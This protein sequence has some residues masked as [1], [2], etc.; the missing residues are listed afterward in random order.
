[1]PE[2]Y[3][4][5]MVWCQG[6]PSPKK[7]Q[8]LVCSDNCTSKVCTTEARGMAFPCSVHFHLLEHDSVA[9]AARVYSISCSCTSRCSY[10][11]GQRHSSTA[12]SSISS[13][14][15]CSRRSSQPQPATTSQRCCHSTKHQEAP[16]QA[17][18]RQHRRRR[19]FAVYRCTQ[20]GFGAASPD[21]STKSAS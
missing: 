18:S 7:C 3:P 14:C 19:C 16:R 8:S 12:V 1:V 20:L 2:G 11:R 6:Y 17:A 9:S 15:P 10:L 13:R 5:I 4:P 21:P